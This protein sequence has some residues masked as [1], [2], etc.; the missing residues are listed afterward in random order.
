MK[1][2]LKNFRIIDEETDSPGI[3]II[4][5][6]II[7]EV[8]SQANE[9][10]AAMIIDARAMN[11]NSQLLLMPAF[12]DLHAHFREPGNLDKETLESGSLAAAAGGFG[13]VVCMANTNPAIDSLEKAQVLKQRSD[14][15]G[16]ID[17]YPVISLTQNLEGKT[18]SGITD[19]SSQADSALVQ[20]D[21]R[22]YPLM[23]SEDGKDIASDD[24][25]LN[26]MKQAKRLGIPISCHCDFGGIEDHAVKRAIEL[27][28]KAG[29]HIH[30]AHVSTKESVEIIQQAKNDA[31]RLKSS[32]K[33]GFSLSCEVMPHHLCLTSETAAR[34]GNETFGRV[35]PALSEHEDREA[36]KAGLMDNTIDTIATDHAPHTIED[37]EKGAPG[38]TA[39]ET[40]FSSCFTEMVLGKAV[41]NTSNTNTHPLLDL[42]QLSSLMSARPARLIGLA[43]RGRLLPGCRADLTIIDT[44][45]FNVVDP[46]HFKSKGKNSPFTGLKLYGRVLMTIQGGRIVYEA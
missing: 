12:V 4:E 2:V 40:A 1:I 37:K 22:Y 3:V 36:L 27:G 24:L 33:E 25:F 39:L 38:F 34:L 11:V 14:A 16:I 45:S 8:N 26:A 29:C 13:T 23:L 44:E 18:L 32:G 10:N 6:G 42:K 9:E 28:K 30:I 5:N 43:D 21:K 15:L 19:M 41:E 35:N 20:E 17:L 31:S 46:Q 7:T